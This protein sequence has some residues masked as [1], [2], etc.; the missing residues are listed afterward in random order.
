MRASLATVLTVRAIDQSVTGSNDVSSIS[1]IGDGSAENH[2]DFNIA[3]GGNLDGLSH[4]IVEICEKSSAA[5]LNSPSIT[6]VESRGALGN[7]S[8]GVSAGGASGVGGSGSGL[9]RSPSLDDVNRTSQA[10]KEKLE[11]R[12]V[13]L[14]KWHLQVQEW[15]NANRRESKDII[16]SYG[17]LVRDLEAVS[18]NIRTEFEKLAEKDEETNLTL[19]Y[20][21]K[22]RGFGREVSC[23]L[24]RSILSMH[25]KINGVYDEYFI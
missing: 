11:Q 7:S 8:N 18:I 21:E 12:R 23:G 14:S 4:R 5:E 22:Y 24:Q 17:T 10:K 16:I 15:L 1:D 3:I 13:L 6:D 25:R 2:Y 9:V 19:E 20:W